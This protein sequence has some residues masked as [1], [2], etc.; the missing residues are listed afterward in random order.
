MKHRWLIVA[1]LVALAL[2]LFAS[3]SFTSI[4]RTDQALAGRMLLWHAL[5]PSETDALN[6][7]INSY[8][9]LNPGV[10]VKVQVFSTTTELNEQFT[11]AARNG[12]GPD[13]ILAPSA[14]LQSLAATQ[15]LAPIDAHLTEN[16]IGR[17]N[18]AIF[19]MLQLD[20]KSYGIPESL[21]TLALYVNRQVVETPATTLDEL[22]EQAN[23]DT[24]VLLPINFTDAFWGIQAFGGRLF[25]DEGQTILEQGG[26]AN[27]L[28]WLREARN[29][30]GMIQDTNRDVLRQRFMTGDA[31][32]YVGYASE[33]ND[34]LTALDPA[35]LT[36][37]PLPNGPV[38]PAGPFVS[39]QAFLFS[40]VSS[41][42][43]RLLAT[44][45]AKFITNSEQSSR[46][47]RLVR[48][49]PANINVR[50]NPR[51]YPVVASF[52]S[53]ARNGIPIPT[54]PEF[55]A[56]VRLGNEAYIRTLE[57]GESPAAVAFDV[58]NSINEANGFAAQSQPTYACTGLGTIDLAHSWQQPDQLATL[59]QIIQNF[60]KT[61]PLVIVE[62]QPL[63]TSEI[64]QN[65]RSQG[66]I[67]E[68]TPFGLVA[69][70]Q[71]NELLTPEPLLMNMNGL[72][73]SQT[74][75]RFS[76]ISL[77]A[78][79]SQGNL[80]GLPLT[81]QVDALYYNRQMVTTPAQTLDDLRSQAMTGISVIID[82]RFEKA[83][84]GIRAFG[85]QFFDANG[86]AILDRG[87]MADWLSWLRA[88]RDNFGIQLSDDGDAIL[89]HFLA[90]DSAYY[91]GGAS[92]LTAL[93]E[94]LGDNLGVALLPGG[95]AGPAQPLV[96]ADGFV[97]R[98]GTKEA[99]QSLALEFMRFATDIDSQ[100]LLMDQTNQIPTNA[101][102]SAANRPLLNIFVEQAQT[103]FVM[104]N[105]PYWQPVVNLG[106]QAY[107][108]VLTRGMEPIQVV[109]DLTAAINRAN[110]IVVTPT[111]TPPVPSS[112]TVPNSDVLR[113]T[114]PT[115]SSQPT[116][117]AVAEPGDKGQSDNGQDDRE[118]GDSTEATPAP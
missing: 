65:F 38:G 55:A 47:M 24:T 28:A 67:R 56:V 92:E 45:L 61:C 40:S 76:P 113:D 1:M 35:M 52:A 50:I 114:T 53:Q 54:R 7:V 112:P 79:R 2:L 36:V 117:D 85:G 104:P 59:D 58:N 33:L 77:E 43:Q 63:D 111:P 17:F 29:A 41:E 82:T 83:F 22:L 97:L 57:G 73:S 12:L 30:P 99:T 13:V 6:Q 93:Q 11:S 81:L 116:G 89:A 42:N 32:Y 109:A 60:R 107:A 26:F 64:L 103:G 19:A 86:A 80:Y 25:N 21:D 31:G 9:E 10:S 62:T 48:H 49:V 115:P 18:P 102:V 68:R 44:S 16:V 15:L 46:L 98:Q 71:L 39:S 101:N 27:W 78:M 66:Q 88:S 96:R 34:I 37:L 5:N 106:Q 118:Q 110:G 14:W 69:Q 3:C 91:V 87:G 95:P 105:T 23:A 8:T 90:G 72:I 94:A 4:R 84:W 51:L 20:G 70:A 74:L 108:D 100:T 75:Q